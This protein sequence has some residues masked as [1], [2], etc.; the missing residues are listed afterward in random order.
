MA[1]LLI[2]CANLFMFSTTALAAAPVE[3]AIQG[4][5]VAIRGSVHKNL[6]GEGF[7]T[8]DQDCNYIT[9]AI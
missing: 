8:K 4:D 1:V 6:S 5:N 2:G 3:V 7:E 9:F